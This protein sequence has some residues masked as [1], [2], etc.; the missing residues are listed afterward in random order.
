MLLL[1][2]VKQDRNALSQVWASGNV[3]TSLWASHP[4]LPSH[5]PGVL[6]PQRWADATGRLATISTICHWLGV[7]ALTHSLTQSCSLVHYA[8]IQVFFISLSLIHTCLEVVRRQ[9]CAQTHGELFHSCLPFWIKYR[10]ATMTTSNFFLPPSLFSGMSHFVSF[11]HWVQ[12]HTCTRIRTHM[13]T[14]T[15]VMATNSTM[16][17]QTDKKFS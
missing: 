14:S 12:T 4:P 5:Q 16:Y 6:D 2:W 13:H 9:L 15:Y 17:P 1:Q 10:H 3:K 7:S 11:P 8:Y